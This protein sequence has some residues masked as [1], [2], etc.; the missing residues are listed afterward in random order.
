MK[1]I[2]RTL[3][4]RHRRDD[5][6]NFIVCRWLYFSGLSEFSY[7]D[8]EL[9]P[10]ALGHALLEAFYFVGFQIQVKCRINWPSEELRTF[11]SISCN[12]NWTGV[13]VLVLESSWFR[14]VLCLQ[15]NCSTWHSAVLFRCH[16][17]QV[18]SAVSHC[19]TSTETVSVTSH[20]FC[21]RRR[22]SGL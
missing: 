10:T 4:E 13:S 12:F 2:F 3:C 8:C 21:V 1:D 19:S 16:N 7:E 9:E 11:E 15:C 17:M 18:V 14:T 20:G 6:L 5:F 22:N